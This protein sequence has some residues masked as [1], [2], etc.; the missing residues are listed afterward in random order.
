MS[1]K[2]LNLGIV[3]IMPKPIQ[4]DSLDDL[5]NKVKEIGDGWRV[6]EW[7]V[8][9]YISSMCKYLGICDYMKSYEYVLTISVSCV[10]IDDNGYSISVMTDELEEIK[11]YID[12]GEAIMYDN[13]GEDY[14][15]S[16]SMV[17]HDDIV[18]QSFYICRPK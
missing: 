3:E 10:I 7:N 6:S 1:N 17:D 9:K 13:D 5:K 16:R 12:G 14:N 2:N 4:I 18:Y 11:N 15:I 8:A